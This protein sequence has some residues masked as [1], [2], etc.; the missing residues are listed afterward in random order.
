MILLTIRA[1]K[2]HVR[3]SGK[4]L[5]KLQYQLKLQQTLQEKSSRFF[6]LPRSYG[7]KIFKYTKY[8]YL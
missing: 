4:K 6:V 2:N 5:Y 1:I 8:R 7:I 3:F